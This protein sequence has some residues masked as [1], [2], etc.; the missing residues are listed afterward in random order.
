MT[1]FACLFY[2]VFF[3]FFVDRTQKSCIFKHI[4]WQQRSFWLCWVTGENI[5]LRGRI[6]HVFR[7]EIPSQVLEEKCFEED[8]FK[9]VFLNL[10]Q[11]KHYVKELQEEYALVQGKK[12]ESLR[13][14]IRKVEVVDNGFLTAALL[15]ERKRSFILSALS[16][17]CLIGLLC[18][19]TL[20]ISELDSALASFVFPPAP[21]EI[22]ETREITAKQFQ[23]MR[24]VDGDTFEIIYDGTPTKVRLVGIDSPD[25]GKERE[26]SKKALENLLMPEKK[27]K[28]VRLEFPTKKKTGQ[29]VK[30]GNFGR[31]LAK[32]YVD[33]LDVNSYMLEKGLA[34]P[35]KR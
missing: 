6:V 21:F 29:I 5:S 34:L 7:V 10:G 2:Y 35:Y 28:T 32:V 20:R 23:V 8:P 22:P 1:Y 11:A 17:L 12:K 33:G 16:F 3:I 18:A 19:F 14:T 9:K 15:A 31:L 27:G 13:C 26:D 24:V 4:L 25:K 30:R